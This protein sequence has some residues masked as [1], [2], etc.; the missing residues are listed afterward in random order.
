MKVSCFSHGSFAQNLT[1]I[2]ATA[3]AS[4]IINQSGLFSWQIY[5]RDWLL[6]WKSQSLHCSLGFPYVDGFITN[7]ILKKCFMVI[8]ICAHMQGL[9]ILYFLQ[10]VSLWVP[11]DFILN[12]F[13]SKCNGCW[14]RRV[15]NFAGGNEPSEWAGTVIVI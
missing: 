8:A 7:Y 1:L 2:W 6:L 14:L 4:L 13:C 15:W 11:Y 5:S 9:S 3:S 12:T 10:K